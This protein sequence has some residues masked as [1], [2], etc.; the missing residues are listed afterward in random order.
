MAA[1]MASRISSILRIPET[2]SSAFDP[3]SVG[4][5]RPGQSQRIVLSSRTIVWKC[6]VLPGVSATATF[7]PPWKRK[8][9]V[10]DPGIQAVVG[11]ACV[12]TQSAFTVVLLP[13]F[14][15]PTI[16]SVTRPS[17]RT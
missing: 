3:E 11:M 6:L 9:S 12:L 14:G 16:P 10:R 4:K 17:S 7:L 1:P 5:T 15:Q 8:Q 2:T 13:T